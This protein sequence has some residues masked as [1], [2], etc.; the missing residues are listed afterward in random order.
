M[1]PEFTRLGSHATILGPLVSANGNWLAPCGTLLLASEH[2][3]ASGYTKTCPQMSP[4]NCMLAPRRTPEMIYQMVPNKSTPWV[5][6]FQGERE[7]MGTTK[8]TRGRKHNCLLYINVQPLS[9]FHLIVSGTKMVPICLPTYQVLRGSL[10]GEICPLSFRPPKMLPDPVTCSPTFLAQSSH[11]TRFS[12][13]TSGQRLA[14]R[15][16]K[17]KMTKM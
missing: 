10:F 14:F 12:S 3:Q 13:K 1:Q 16:Q 5:F 15:P 9:Q 6:F 8:A 7:F 2:S 17:S 11:M 4:H